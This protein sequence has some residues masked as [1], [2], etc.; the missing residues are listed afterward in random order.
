MRISEI[1][2]RANVT[3]FDY[4]HEAFLA[5]S[6]MN[7]RRQR[8]CLYFK[9]GAGKSLTALGCLAIWDFHEVL[10]ISP[11]STHPRWVA[12]GKALGITVHPMSHAKFRM[13]DTKL[14]RTM[15]II[16]DEMHLFGG[17]TGKGW[18]KLD[19]LGM[20]LQAPLILASATPNYN[21]AERVYCIQH[22]LDPVTTKG[23]FIA[24]LYKN[25]ETEPNHFS[26]TPNVTGFLHYAD[27]AEYL[28]ALPGVLYLKDDLVYSITDIPI[29]VPPTPHLDKYGYDEHGHK[30]VASQMEER[31]LRTYQW[32]VNTSSRRVRNAPYATVLDLVNTSKTPV[33]V[34]AAHS[35]I[36]E[37]LYRSLADEGTNVGVVT[38]DA[39]PRQKDEQIDL[40]IRGKT[41]VLIG[42]ASLATGTDG[43]DKVC[44]R[45]IIFDD[46][47]DDALRR[48]LIGRIMPRGS[49]VNSSKKNVYR[50][51]R[52]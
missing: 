6:A 44:D 28:A 49:A 1:A 2:E 34:F 26:E 5:A 40:F 30:M 41:D 13:K 11:P 8:I 36:A 16:A 37:A 4:Q 25:C 51:V 12:W 3:L 52:Q 24:F 7:G 48:Q 19:Q 45:L 17:H 43:M 32:L 42:T 14:S 35:K 31:H 18:K 22:I 46:T 21:D 9:T 10:V 15:P 39:T 23:G 33:L 50:L 38:G 27:A 29:Q 47:D 20:H